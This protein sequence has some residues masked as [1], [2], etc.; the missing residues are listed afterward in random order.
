M[1]I[2][3]ISD[4]HAN[5]PALQAVLGAIDEL[6][7]V[8]ILCGGDL[9][10]YGP[11]PCE[12]VELVRE[13]KISC[14]RGNHDHM[15]LHTGRVA[16]LRPDVRDSLEWTREQ[17][18]GETIQWL[19]QLPRSMTYGGVEIVHASHV[20]RPEWQYV[21]DRRSV[22]LNFLFQG[23][24]LAFNG[25]SHVPLVA[26]HRPGERARMVELGEK[27]LPPGYR[28][29]VNVGSVG[30]PRDRNP[31]AAFVT[32]ETRDRR[33]VLHRVK[34]DVGKTQRDIAAADLPESLGLRLS[35]GR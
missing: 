33:V 24:P 31:M 30:Q 15:M 34:Y 21:I 13:R 27:C 1:K 6:D 7:C 26:L 22:T 12:C 8:R 25:H 10:G 9:V 11:H 5:L 29:M 19:G 18:G 23:C 16:K 14:V 28:Y 35:E 3:L 4:I 32:F 2:A 17:L 20:I